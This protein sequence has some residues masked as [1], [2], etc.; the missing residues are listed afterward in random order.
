MLPSPAD[1]FAMLASPDNGQPQFAPEPNEN[2]P[3][4]SREIGITIGD[5]GFGA[6]VRWRS[7]AT[8]AAPPTTPCMRIWESRLALNPWTASLDADASSVIPHCPLLTLGGSVQVSFQ[9]AQGAVLVL[10]VGATRED[11][12]I[13]L[14]FRQHIQENADAWYAF[15]TKAGFLP[16]ARGIRNS[17]NSL[18]VV[19]GCDKTSTWAL[20]TASRQRGCAE[21]GVTLSL[22][23]VGEA[24]LVPRFEW[25]QSA[26]ATVRVGG[27][28]GSVQQNQCVFVRGFWVPRSGILERTLKRILGKGGGARNADTS[29]QFA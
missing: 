11:I 4:E 14:P 29:V 23:G 13:D 5:W 9:S 28:I 7:L 15:A 3:A 1:I 27:D 17:N 12:R 19:T 8:C 20:A 6:T 18:F 26:T 16:E 22:G 10:P 21:F 25:Q 2:L 24:R